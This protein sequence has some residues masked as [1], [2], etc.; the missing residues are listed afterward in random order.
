MS[1][2]D[3][4]GSAAGSAVA[5]GVI[6]L[7]SDDKSKTSSASK[8][9]LGSAGSGSSSFGDMVRQ[10][11]STRQ[12]ALAQSKTTPYRG[13]PLKNVAMYNM[14]NI[15]TENVRQALVAQLIRNNAPASQVQAILA[16]WNLS[17][18]KLIEPRKSS[19]IGF[20]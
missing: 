6:N 4:L 13:E 1:F 5:M 3:T 9:A 19:K 7:F 15:D 20:A 14:K 2:W 16:S 17:D 10:S 8:Q 12:T 18:Q 11:S